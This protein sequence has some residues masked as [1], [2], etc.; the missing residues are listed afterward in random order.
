MIIP[1]EGNVNYPIT[2]DASVW[3]FD[4]RKIAFEDAFLPEKSIKKKK[5]KIDPVK[6]T[7]ERLNKAYETNMRKPINRNLNREER[8][9]AL[10]K[11][12]VMPLKQFIKHTEPKQSATKAILVTSEGDVEIPLENLKNSLLHFSN[13]GK[14]ITEK[15]P[16]HLYY[17]DG[18]NKENPIKGITKIIIR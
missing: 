11:S 5:K 9:A 14:P 17:Q 15:G 13:K 18:S 1:I 10:Q 3:I 7:A 4:D 8:E 16:V 12:F 6:Q 2:L